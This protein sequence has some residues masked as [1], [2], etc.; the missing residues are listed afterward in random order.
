MSNSNEKNPVVLGEELDQENFPVLRRAALHDLPHLESQ[1]RSVANAWHEGDVVSALQALE[2]DLEHNGYDNVDT[3]AVML[4]GF[5]Y[6]AEKQ[7]EHSNLRLSVDGKT[8]FS[9]ALL[10]GGVAGGMAQAFL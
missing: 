7:R 6:L 9:V 10:I 2:S 1:V 8:W 5:K 4:V 3:K